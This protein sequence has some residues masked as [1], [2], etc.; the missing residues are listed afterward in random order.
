[1]G[2][3]HNTAMSQ[4][5]P[6]SACAKTAGTWAPTIT[7]DVITDVRSA[8]DATWNTI[9]PLNV[10][11]NSA[12]R[13]GSCIASVDV[14]FLI[15]T[16]D[17]DSVAAKME[18]VSLTA[19]GTAPTGAEETAITYDSNH[20]SAAKRYA[21]GSHTMTITFTTPPWLSNK[22][23]YY[24]LLVCDAAASSVFTFKGARINYT[25]RD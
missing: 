12:Y 7:S 24:L 1:M 21:Q 15:G 23:A 3:T 17:M 6:P 11:G 20:D 18:H 25:E 16:A 4:F 8:A 14:Y 9:I 22:D 10:P 13:E 2:Y 5:I 19:S